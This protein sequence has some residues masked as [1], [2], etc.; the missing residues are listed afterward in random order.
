MKEPVRLLEKE[1]SPETR[2][3]GMRSSLFLVLCFL[4][5]SA[6]FVS[7]WRRR[8]DPLALMPSRRVGLSRRWQQEQQQEDRQQQEQQG[9]EGGI[10][11]APETPSFVIISYRAA[12]SLSGLALTLSGT[13]PELLGQAGVPGGTDVSALTQASTIFAALAGIAAPFDREQGIEPATVAGVRKRGGW[14]LRATAI[15]LLAF[16]ITV[17][18][19]EITDTCSN[20]EIAMLCVREALWFGLEYKLEGAVA[21]L[22][23]ALGIRGLAGLGVLVLGSAKFLEPLDADRVP[24]Q[25]DFFRDTPLG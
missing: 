3:H 25:S 2:T 8:A 23:I 10:S 19:S 6:G 11:L 9:D 7:N 1:R 15:L 4:G 20:L 5:L 14:V 18:A 16:A 13:L 24:G 21:V 22:G 12:L 17:P